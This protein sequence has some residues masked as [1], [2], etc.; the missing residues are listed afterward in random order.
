MLGLAAGT[1]QLAVT[2]A[3]ASTHATIEARTEAPLKSTA[4]TLVKIELMKS[5]RESGGALVS[6]SSKG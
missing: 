1:V 5:H 2:T 6:V 4:V 3:K